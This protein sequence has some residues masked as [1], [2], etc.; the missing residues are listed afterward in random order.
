MAGDVLTSD[1]YYSGETLSEAFGNYSALVTNNT[2]V[3]ATTAQ[4][5][6]AALESFVRGAKAGRLDFS[7]IM[8][9]R[10]AADF[11]RPPPGETAYHH[12]I[13]SAAGAFPPS[14]MNIYLAG[15]KVVMGVVQQWDHVFGPGI[16]PSN[17][18]GDLFGTLGGKPDFGPY[19]YFGEA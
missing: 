17:Y 2:A 19:P 11:D 14:L 6:A 13:A 1:V 3:Y 5:D 7:R 15:I 12:L 16:S 9:M 8:V 10:T 4:E 18:L